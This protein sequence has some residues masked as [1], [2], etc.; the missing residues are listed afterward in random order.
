MST[1]S[2][3]SA[4]LI[5]NALWRGALFGVA[6]ALGYTATNIFLK[7]VAEYDPFFVSCLK[8]VPVV[9]MSIVLAWSERGNSAVRRLSPRLL[10]VLIATGVVV[11]VVGNAGY[12]WALLRLGLALTVPLSFA[13]IIAGGAILSRM[14]LGEPITPR[15]ALAMLVIVA[16]VATLSLGAKE[17]NLEAGAPLGRGAVALG[18]VVAC[19]S[20]LAY[21]LSGVVI[22][23]SCNEQASLPMTLGIY[24]LTGVVLLGA[25]SIVNMGWEGWS[26]APQTADVATRL[27]SVLITGCNALAATPPSALGVMLLAGVFNAVA[28]L[29]LGKALT[30]LSVVLVNALNA[31]QAALSAVAG[32]VLFQEP[33]TPGLVIGSVLTIV[34]LLMTDR[35]GSPAEEEAVVETALEEGPPLPHRQTAETA[36]KS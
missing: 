12:Q 28:F 36:G 6:S 32:V 14:F 1:S 11:Q 24:S 25:L 16:A 13:W 30:Y 17:A 15:S 20:G 35:R 29:A 9:L 7:G 26:T 27:L 21:S 2:P 19:A 5:R 3:R 8:N 4:A 33:L 23:A 31:S 34:G 18:V 10:A 22:R